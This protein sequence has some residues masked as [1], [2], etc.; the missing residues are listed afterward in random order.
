MDHQVIGTAVPVLEMKPS[1]GESVVA[2][3]GELS[4]MTSSIQLETAGSTTCRPD[5]AGPAPTRARALTDS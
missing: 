2:E 3:S 4:W 5:G 1:P